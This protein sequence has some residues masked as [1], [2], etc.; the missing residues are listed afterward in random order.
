[1]TP[2]SLIDQ[3]NNQVINQRRARERGDAKSVLQ[4]RSMIEETLYHL[5]TL[6]YDRLECLEACD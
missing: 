5:E 2:Q 1:M 4:Y 6:G 3:L